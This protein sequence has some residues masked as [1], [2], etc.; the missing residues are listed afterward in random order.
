MICG[1]AESIPIPYSECLNSGPA[2]QFIHVLYADGVWAN[3]GVRYITTLSQSS[4]CFP[5]NYTPT[6]NQGVQLRYF[7]S[8][9]IFLKPSSDPRIS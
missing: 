9:D 2:K 7:F 6:R 8:E 3:Y 1:V 5:I 4:P